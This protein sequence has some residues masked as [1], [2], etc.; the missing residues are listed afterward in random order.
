MLPTQIYL[1]PV[2]DRRVAPPPGEG[3]VPEPDCLD[4]DQSGVLAEVAA[5]LLRLAAGPAA[6]F[7]QGPLNTDNHC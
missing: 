5:L 6:A 3:V 1:Q 4:H 7:G 2:D